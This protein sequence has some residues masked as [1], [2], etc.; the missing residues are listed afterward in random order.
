MEYYKN[1]DLGDIRYIDDD[2][3]SQI[4]EWHDISNYEGYYQISNLSRVKSLAKLINYHKHHI[5]RTKDCIL[6]QSSHQKAGHLYLNLYKYGQ[7]KTFGVHVLVALTHIP[8]PFNLSLIEHL[9][10]IPTDNRPENLMWSTVSSNLQNA[11]NRGLKLPNKGE[12]NGRSKL[13]KKQVLEIRDSDS[14]TCELAKIYGVTPVTI[15]SIKTRKIWKH[16]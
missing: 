8:N 13:N 15:A 16:I 4:E 2:G 9:N 1:L 3:I 10:D 6:K 14:R 11:Y 5:R 12:S 7:R